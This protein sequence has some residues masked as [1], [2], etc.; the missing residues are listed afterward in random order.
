[1]ARSQTHSLLPMRKTEF[2]DAGEERLAI[3][4]R[5][6]PSPNMGRV[7]LFGCL[8]PDETHGTRLKQELAT[9]LEAKWPRPE[10]Q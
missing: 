7:R 6:Q 1:M 2:L 8:L 5:T 3:V 9:A 10:G 4:I